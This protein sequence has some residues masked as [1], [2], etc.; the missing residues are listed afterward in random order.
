MRSIEQIHAVECLESAKD[1]LVRFGGHPKAAGFTVR[2][3]NIDALRAR[4]NAFVERRVEPDQLV[5]TRNYD[6]EIQPQEVSET[7]RQDL[8]RLGPFGMGNPQPRLLLRNVE[9]SNIQVRGKTGSLLKFQPGPH[10]R[11]VEAIWWGQSTHAEAL[12]KQRVDLLGSLGSNRWQ[13]RETLQFKVD[14]VRSARDPS[15]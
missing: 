13:G 1:L 9:P 4:M 8:L 14:D 15:S 12:G 10:L 5:L 6:C 2:T 7:T 3:E 11:G